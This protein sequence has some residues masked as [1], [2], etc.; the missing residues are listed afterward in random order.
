M[1]TFTTTNTT[2]NLTSPLPSP[3]VAHP[4]SSDIPCLAPVLFV[5]S[6][7][8]ITIII[9]ALFFAAKCPPNPFRRRQ[10]SSGEPHLELTTKTTHV[11]SVSSSVKF[12]EDENGRELH[13]GAGECPV[14]LSA[15]V[16]GEELRLL[17]SC[18]HVFHAPCINAWLS[19]HSNCPVCRAIV[20]VGRRSKRP[21][22]DE[23]HD[24]QQGLPDSASLV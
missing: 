22:V 2:N 9:Y 18:E 17:N 13:C 4:H 23:D 15:F 11:E 20:I 5:A 1:A 3:V 14:C 10:R 7:V 6:F 21:A 24:L 8:V 12:E 19:S 16:A